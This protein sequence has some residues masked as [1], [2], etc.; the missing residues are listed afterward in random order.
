MNPN[1]TDCKSTLVRNRKVFQYSCLT[2]HTCNCDI[3]APERSP[4]CVKRSLP[5]MW[6]ALAANM[7][8]P[9]CE[10]SAALPK[11]EFVAGSVMWC[12]GGRMS[13][14]EWVSS[15]SDSG[16]AHLD[17]T[18]DE[19]C[20]LAFLSRT[21][22]ECSRPRCRRFNALWGRTGKWPG[23]QGITVT[24]ALSFEELL[25]NHLPSCTP[26][27]PPS[28][29]HSYLTGSVCLTLT[30]FVSC[31]CVSTAT[32]CCVVSSEVCSCTAR[33]PLF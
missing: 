29:T 4:V 16:G 27:F 2:G 15:L 5:W 3:L 10:L 11:C 20:S 18:A 8:E 13:A 7:L 31:F 14:A 21:T 24:K 12:N 23:L 28:P 22:N 17:G 32:P 19:R 6:A 9:C 25:T 33:V 1:L 26:L 30:G